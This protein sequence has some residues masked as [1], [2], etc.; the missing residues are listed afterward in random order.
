MQTTMNQIIENID[1]IKT[2]TFTPENERAT[3][4]VA[5]ERINSR[6]FAGSKDQ[7]I[8][9]YVMI[10]TRETARTRKMFKVSIVRDIRNDK[11]SEITIADMRNEKGNSVFRFENYAGYAD[12]AMTHAIEIETE[13]L[14]AVNDAETVE[15]NENDDKEAQISE[16]ESDYA[17]ICELRLRSNKMLRDGNEDAARSLAD[18]AST[19]NVLASIKLFDYNLTKYAQTLDRASRKSVI[20]VREVAD[21][22]QHDYAS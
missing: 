13:A 14:N 22:M 7:A 2:S 21:R 17:I 15:S 12:A 6:V 8:V 9:E 10:V 5:V 1:S 11:L 16:I 19:L 3:Y 18:A 20:E 4:T